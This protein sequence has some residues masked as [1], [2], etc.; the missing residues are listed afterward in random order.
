MEIH[1]EQE[2][3]FHQLQLSCKFWLVFSDPVICYHIGIVKLS[4]LQYL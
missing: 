3:A 2:Q 1:A 4:V